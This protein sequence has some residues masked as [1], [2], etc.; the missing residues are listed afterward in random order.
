MNFPI[1]TFLTF[2]PV[3]GMVII[4]FLKK[5]NVQAIKYTALFATGVQLILSIFLM[6]NYNYLL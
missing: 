4:L 6:S 1:L 2:I 3:V 5:E